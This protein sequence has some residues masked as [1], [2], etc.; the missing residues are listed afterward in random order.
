MRQI[1][2]AAERGSTWVDGGLLLAALLALPAAL[3]LREASYLQVHDGFAHLFR[4]LALDN[5]LTQGVWY[6]RW[7]PEL[8]FGLGYPIF[9][10][11][12]PLVSYAAELFHLLGAT[13]TDA[14]RLLVAL[15]IVGAALAMYGYLRPWA[16]CWG[17]LLGAAAYVYLPY[18]LLNVYVR[19]SFA[20]QVCFPLFPLA[21]FLADRAFRDDGAVRL[22]PALGLALTLALLILG[23]NPSALVFN[24]VLAV[25]L[26]WRW[27]WRGWRALTCW[28]GGVGLVFGLALSL[29][30]F[31]WLPFLVELPDTWIGTFRTGV[32]DFYRAL[33]PLSGLVQRSLRYDYELVWETTVALGAVQAGLALLGAL[34]LLRLPPGARQR[35]AFGVGV[36]LVGCLLLTRSAEPFWRAVPLASLMT[37]PWRL[38]AVLGLATAIAA[39]GVPWAVGRFAPLAALTLGALAGWAALGGL[40]TNPLALDDALVSR[41]SAAR[42]D[43]SG[44]LTGTTSPPQFVP[45]WA[46]SPVQQFAHPTSTPA[47]GVGAVIR[48]GEVVSFDGWGYRL[49]LDVAEPGPLRVRTF[50]FPGWSATIDGMPV[51]LWPDGPAGEIALALPAGRHEVTIAFG[52][53]PARRLGEFLSL[54][55]L[56]VLLGALVVCLRQR[57]RW[58]VPPL[59]AAGVVLAVVLPTVPRAEAVVRSEAS[60]G[61]ALRL[62]GWRPDYRDLERRGV[63][64]LELLWLTGTPPGGEVRTRLRLLDERGEPVAEQDRP[65]VYG[66][67]PSSRWGA[68]TLVLDSYDLPLWDGFPPGSYRLEL[69]VRPEE[70]SP[71]QVDPRPQVIG[72]LAIGRSPHLPRRQ[73]QEE[74]DI[75]YGGLA[76]LR[77]FDLA[78]V[79]PGRAP[80]LRAG[81]SFRLALYWSA[82]RPIDQDYSTFVHLSDDRYQPVAQQDSFGGFD[83]RF[84]TLWEPGRIIRDQYELLVPATTPPGRYWLTAGLFDRTDGSRLP[85]TTAR[86]EPLDSAARLTPLL[87]WAREPLPSP[88]RPAAGEWPGLAR[89]LGY[90]LP[91]LPEPVLR[92]CR[93]LRAPCEESLV[94]HWESTASPTEDLTIFLHLRDPNGRIVLQS[95]GPPRLGRL[96]TSFLAPGDRFLDPRPLLGLNALPSGRYQLVVGWYRPSDGQ[97]LAAREGESIVLGELVRP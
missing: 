87:V 37:F 9:N 46:A 88:T 41:A 97:R 24:A 42:L 56:G 38:Q 96:P 63:V 84:P 68:A 43:R 7:S 13:Y 44:A 79:A 65:P 23:H 58:L 2:V 22:L 8:V 4:L 21:L 70:G 33:Q 60:F 89:L 10:F 40:A 25:A 16:G 1:R 64:R 17:A 11:Y 18:H 75:R 69:L 55:G 34:A 77:G 45:R 50:Y 52:T 39:A 67:A 61:P 28:T 94:L 30:A 31:F 53:T 92:D 20:E 74:R 35:A 86:G 49:R 90:D 36:T 93:A 15:T 82:L 5:A 83:L 12:N 71:A 47:S 26:C 91:P 57:L 66:T 72:Q 62:L 81:E 48:D 59:L 29:T 54:V 76:Q 80:S 14:L 32:E 73:P 27:R 3:P 6:P 78:G 85:A 19:G 51:A 95:D